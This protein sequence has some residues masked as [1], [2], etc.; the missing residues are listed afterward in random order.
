MSAVRRLVSYS[1]GA[2]CG[3]KLGPAELATVIA[4]LAP[5][6]ADARLLVGYDTGDDA[7]VYRIDDATA[8]VFTT[9]FFTPI[10]DDAR[11]WGR[12]AAANALSD[13]YAMGGRPLLC[14][15][16][17]AWPRESLPLEVLAEVLAGG[18]EVAREAGAVVAGGHTIDDPEPKYGMAVAGL[19]HPDR[20]VTNAGARPGDLLV[21]TKPLGTGVI[22]TAHK[23]DA[24]P[25]EVLERAVRV[26]TALNASASAAMIAAGARAATDVTGFGFLGHLGRMLEA[27][28]VSAS[29]EADAV[30]LI[31]GAREL[32]EQGH[33]AGGTRRNRGYVEPR[34]RFGDG[35][36]ETS[37]W[38]L[39]DAQTSGG[40]VIACPPEGLDDLGAA[41]V[42]AAVVGAVEAGEAGAIDVR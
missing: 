30:P 2:G 23:N 12:I 41:A 31:D 21:L 35:V 22:A 3:C 15:N 40:L 7:A 8:L 24:A 38:L 32:A 6:E 14:L 20:V 11:A 28:G 10:V 13:V 5:A 39:F 26:M 25:P 4:R 33:I 16:V 29:I 34:V 18:A 19:V 42:G 17:T 1:H 36:D 27:S 9:D 37:R